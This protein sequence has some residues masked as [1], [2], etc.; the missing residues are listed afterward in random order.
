[1][2]RPEIDSFYHL[3]TAG[4]AGRAC[5]GTA[6]FV[7]RH[8]NTA[9]WEKTAA[10]SPRLYCLGRCYAAPAVASGKDERPVIEVRCRQGIVLNRIVAGGARTFAAYVQH[11]GYQAL[12]KALGQPQEELVRKMEASG[13]RGL[14]GAG[15]SAGRKWRAVL[16]APASQKFVV[17]NF[18]EGDPGAYIDRFLVEEDPH[19]LI[20]AMA[21]AA[22]A[23][24]AR[25]GYV[26]VRNEY[27]QAEAVLRGALAEARSE[28]LLGQRILN[29]DFSFDINIHTGRGSY[30]CGEE[31]ALL[32]SIEGKR[33]EVRARPPFPAQQGLFGLPTLVHNVETLAN[34]PWL[35]EHGAEKFQRLGFSQS[36]GNKVVSLNSLFARPGL[37]EVEIGVPLRHIVEDLGGG[38]KTGSLKGVII[39]GPLAGIVPPHLL[40]TPFGFEELHAIHASVGHGGIVAFDERASIPELVHHVFSFA[41]YESCGKCTPCRLSSRRVEQIFQHM[42]NQRP[43]GPA[44][45]IEWT[46]ILTALRLTSLCGLGTGLAEFA[47]S[48]RRYYAAELEQCFT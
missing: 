4:V 15:F 26:Y 35:V 9:Q 2:V 31:T 41:A 22:Y 14:G 11:G 5:Q 28:N 1:M 30:V 12:E 19:S 42:L 24:G 44:Q 43:G 27:P 32:N 13:L 45:E 34:V 37:Y 3:S 48:A 18:D 36:R 47:E 29:R 33:P 46:D 40:D 7:A 10:Q 39:G 17:A 16:E 8:R 25:E 23:V 38:L 6:C 20:E 21:I